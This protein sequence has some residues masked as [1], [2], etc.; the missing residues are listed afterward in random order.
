MRTTS[1][2][3]LFRLHIIIKIKTLWGCTVDFDIMCIIYDKDHMS[4]LWIKNTSESD[5]RSYEVTKA[6]TK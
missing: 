5:P 4:A 1:H 6:V 3:V 2:L